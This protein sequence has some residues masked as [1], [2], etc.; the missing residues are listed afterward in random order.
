MPQGMGVQPLFLMFGG[1]SMTDKGAALK[2]HTG[3]LDRLRADG[4][5]AA[6]GPT[7]GQNALLSIVVFN[8]I[9]IDEATKLMA[10]D[11]AVKSGALKAESHQWWCAEHVFMAPLSDN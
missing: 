5:I 6:A 8:R 2:A 7:E 10:D 1:P 11:P 3:Y 4:K 9:S